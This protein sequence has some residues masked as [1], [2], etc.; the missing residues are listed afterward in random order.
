V[1]DFGVE[2]HGTIYLLRPLTER[3][4]TWVNEHLPEDAQWFDDAVAVEHRF[5][6]DIV[7]G[8][9]TDGLRVR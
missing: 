3:A 7:V 4:V 8:V 6:H 2:N 5:I 9:V 1:A